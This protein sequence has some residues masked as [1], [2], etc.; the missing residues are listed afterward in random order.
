MQDQKNLILAIVFSVAIILV[1][2]LVI[3]PPNRPAPQTTTQPSAPGVPGTP[4]APPA[5]TPPGTTPPGTT[6]GTPPAAATP[7]GTQPATPGTPPAA[8][9]RTA[10][11]ED[12]LKA[13]PRVAID[14]KRIVG[15][16]S[17]KGGALDDVTLRDYRE[18]VKKDSASVHLLNPANRPPRAVRRWTCRTRILFGPRIRR[19]CRPASPSRSPGRIRKA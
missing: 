4:G 16:I 18:T 1:F 17:L 5:A 7:P 10:S 13:S 9:P 15:S 8:P 12:L 6:P 3:S 11:R 14:A 2:Q 19:R